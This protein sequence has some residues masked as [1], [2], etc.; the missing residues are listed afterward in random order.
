M[1]KT[2]IL[3]N[4]PP[5][6]GKDTVAAIMKKKMRSTEL[7]KMASPLKKAFGALLNLDS[8]LLY[9]LT[10]TDSKDRPIWREFPTTPRDILIKLSE[11]V[12][13]PFFGPD[14]FGV[15]AVQG[16]DQI[17][18][19]RVVISDIGFTEEVVPIAK[20]YGY[21]RVFGLAI[22]REGHDFENDSRCY[23]DFHN[24][25]LEWDWLRNDHDLELLEAQVVR[26]LKKWKLIDE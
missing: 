7:Y 18:A 16:I 3:L 19:S 8:K 13:K 17:I 2:I 22:S 9:G 1:S 24:L 11:D 5:G 12:M 21:N 20:R 4:G 15:I 26:V 25:G 23:I 6:C 10:E 14:I